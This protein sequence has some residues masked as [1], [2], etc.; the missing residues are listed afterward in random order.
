MK[1]ARLA[2]LMLV[3]LLA[4]LFSVA[5]GRDANW[6]FLNYRWYNPYAFL[7]GKLR[8]DALVA[9]HAT[10]YNPLLELPFYLLATH[11]PAIVAGFGVAVVDGACF[12]PLFMIAERTLPLQG[13]A[14]IAVPAVVAL[15]GLTGGGALGQIGVISWDMALGLFSL[16]SI[17]VLLGRDADALRSPAIGASK[18]LLLAGFLA[19]SAAG[20]KLTAAVYPFG[21]VTALFVASSGS[22][23]NRVRRA[24]L[25]AIGAI[26]GVALFGGYWMLQLYGAFGSPTLP[27]FNN[28]IHSPY[29]GAGN[30]RDATFLPHDWWTALLFPFL[31][32]LNS[33]RVAE[34]D[35]CDV[36]IAVAL[37][38]IAAAALVAVGR[39]HRRPG[40][41]PILLF[42]STAFVVTFAA[43]EY[44]FSIYRYIIPLEML[45]VVIAA[46]SLGHFG[47]P[48]RVLPWV[49][50]GLM[51]VM[52]GFVQAGF[53]RRA[54]DRSYVETQLPFAVPADAMVLMTGAGP[55]GFAVAALP[56]TVAVLRPDSYLAAGNEFEIIMK[57][58]IAGHTGPF[59]T[60]FTPGE[61]ESARAALARSGLSVDQASCG[62]INS[63]VAGP[64][65]L[66]RVSRQ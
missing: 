15:A 23:R 63:N 6:D 65:D 32:T 35:F 60:I 39:R 30:N 11:V 37:A 53:N 27:Y 2:I 51:A 55:M 1:Y 43:W 19:G 40:G 58:R 44:L 50:V 29:A 38:T 66:C 41:T 24:A 54:W 8:L 36:H 48:G 14:R 57:R 3:P 21:I 13:K 31:F 61:A 17:A 56:E 4:G 26:G 33:R 46:A 34:Y 49:M 47:L 16:G 62:Q 59:L 7:H 42:L 52:A 5:E 10:F 18:R 20:L 22:F 25:F 12:V 9:G 28:L 45:A 64:L